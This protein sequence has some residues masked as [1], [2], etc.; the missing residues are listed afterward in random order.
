MISYTELCLCL[1]TGIIRV[2]SVTYKN[3]LRNSALCFTRHYEGF[4]PFSDQK[5]RIARPISYHSRDSYNL[6]PFTT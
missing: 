6:L 2:A 5:E 1:I 3:V 4:V